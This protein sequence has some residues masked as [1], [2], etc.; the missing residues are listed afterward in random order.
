[1]LD[2][3]TLDWEK[4]NFLL[5]AIVQDAFDG[6][7]LMQGYMNRESLEKSLQS[8]KVTFWSRS[9]KALWTKGE[10]SGNY[11]DLVQVIADC[12]NDALLVL[13]R[14][15]GPVCHLETPTCFDCDGKKMPSLQ[16]LAEL[17]HIIAQRDQDRPPGSYTTDLFESGVKRMAQK[18][19]EEAVETA[20]AAAAGDKKELL[21]ESA[22][23]IYHLL[24]LL[25]SQG[26]SLEQ[27]TEVLNARHAN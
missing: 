2:I 19:G 10:T 22:D 7:V 26:C 18:V 14:P 3:E 4:M 1:M 9:R 27:L 24:V 15:H 16:F 11:L 6:R 13:A 21:D 23:L 8:G 25:R 20:L 5:P 12:D 17:E